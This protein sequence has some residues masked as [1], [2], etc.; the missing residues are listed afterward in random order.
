[1]PAGE[2]TAVILY[3]YTSGDGCID[4]AARVI[5]VLDAP[6]FTCGNPVT[7]IRDGSIYPTVLVGTQCWMAVNLNFGS[8]IDLSA[9][10]LDNCTP[11]KYCYENDPANCTAKGGLY[12]WDEMMQYQT[13]EGL[14]GICPPGWHVPVETEWQ[15][16]F[17]QFGGQAYAGD[18][19]KTGG[20]FRSK[21]FD[22][23]C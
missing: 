17:D 22:V 8:R 14:Q 5:T 7:D 19:I 12:T 6:T 18:A 2:D 15:A 9:T 13:T 11:E 3:T 10:P 23:R 4:S 1:M 21:W 20:S 16:L